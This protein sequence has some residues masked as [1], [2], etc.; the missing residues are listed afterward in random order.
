[1]KNRFEKIL[2]TNRFQFSVKLAICILLA[3]ANF[4]IGEILSVGDDDVI[5]K[6]NAHQLAGSFDAFC[7]F[8]IIFAGRKVA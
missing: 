7:Q 6:V 4:V 2:S 1:M 8:V 5:Q 3:F